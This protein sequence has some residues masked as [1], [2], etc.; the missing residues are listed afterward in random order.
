MAEDLPPLQ[1]EFDDVCPLYNSQDALVAA[2]EHRAD[3]DELVVV[4]GYN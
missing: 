3:E 4:L 1:G 2:P